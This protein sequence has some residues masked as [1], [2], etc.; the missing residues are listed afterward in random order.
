MPSAAWR[1]CVYSV[2][3][4]LDISERRQ[5]EQQLHYLADHDPL[6]GLYNRRR[7]EAELE[8][9]VTRGSGVATRSAAL[10]VLDLDGFKVA[11]D[12]FGHSVGDDLVDARRG[13][14]ASE[15]AQERLHRAARRRRVRDHP[16]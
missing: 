15:R 7:F 9:T 4:V 10:L 13:P 5:F 11:N 2:T 12:R 1:P 8:R 3:Q 16:A 6:T 14:A